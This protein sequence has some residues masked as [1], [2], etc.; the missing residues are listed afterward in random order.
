MGNAGTKVFIQKKYSFKYSFVFFMDIFLE[1]IKRFS[2]ISGCKVA[3]WVFPFLISDGSFLLVY[4]AGIIC[5]F[6]GKPF[7]DREDRYY[8][9]REGRRLWFTEQ[10]SD[11][12]A[13]SF[14]ITIVTVIISWLLLFPMLEFRYDWGKVI[15][16]LAKTDAGQITGLF[17][18]ISYWFLNSHEPLE[19]MFISVIIISLGSCF[20]GMLMVLIRL[21]LPPAYSVGVAVV[22]VVYSFIVLNVNGMHEKLLFQISPVSWMRITRLGYMEYGVRVAWPASVSIGVFAVLLLVIGIAGHC[23]IRKVDFN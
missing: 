1:P 17:W 3:P 15:F 13:S 9:I 21:Y 5:F 11:I 19:A 10:L 18:N 14:I 6:S 8:L 16:T 7:M 23:R 12:F 2:L 4:M 20:L 22:L